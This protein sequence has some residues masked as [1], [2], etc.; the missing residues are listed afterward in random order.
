MRDSTKLYIETELNCHIKVDMEAC[1][2][3]GYDWFDYF[4]NKNITE[5]D[6]K[7]IN[8]CF[9]GYL[10]NTKPEEYDEN[11]E[12]DFSLIQLRVAETLFKNECDLNKIRKAHLLIDPD[13][14]FSGDWSDEPGYEESYCIG[15]DTYLI[16]EAD[17][18]DYILRV[19]SDYYDNCDLSFEQADFIAKF[20]E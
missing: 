14:D 20:E 19:D 11:I 6:L 8:K 5:E 9:Y 4:V 18:A 1:S 15:G 7:Y 12:C 16:L 17:D 10:T 3:N 13:C 2:E